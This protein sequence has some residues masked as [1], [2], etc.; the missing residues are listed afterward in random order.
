MAYFKQLTFGGIAPAMSPRLLPEP[1]GQTSQNIDFDSGR[2]TP[3]KTDTDALTLNSANKKSI[4]LYQKPLYIDAWDS[5]KT[6]VAGNLV[7]H[8]NN[9]WK[10][11]QGNNNQTPAGS[12]SANWT[13]LGTTADQWFQ[14]DEANISAHQGPI[15]NDT[16]GR[17]Y[18]TGE[19]YPRISNY[20]IAIQSTTGPYPAS[21]NGSYRLGVPAPAS[22]QTPTVSK[23]VAT[24][25]VGA[26]SYA[27]H[28]L[29]K[30]EQ[31]DITNVYRAK[32]SHTSAAANEPPNDTFWTDL[33][34]LDEQ[35]PNDVSYV[36]TI[37]S[38]FGEEGPPS[39]A[40]A[41]IQ[42]VDNEDVTV[43]LNYTAGSSVFNGYNISTSGGAKVYIYRSNTGSKNTT[44]QFAGEVA[45]GTTTFTD[46]NTALTLAE[47]LP[48]TT[49]IHPPNDDT[50]LYP[51][52]PLQ[53]LT[54]LPNGM[55]AGFTG[56]RFC[57]SEPFLPHAWPIQYR[58]TVDR[59]IVAIA[60]TRNGIMAL[61]DGK[62]AFVTGQNPSAMVSTSID[63][64][65][66]CINKSSVVDMGDYVLYAGP[67]G[68][69]RVEN[70]QG[71]VL[72]EQQITPQQWNSSTG[73]FRPSIIKAFR[74][75]NTYVAFWEDSG[76]YGG[77]AYDPRRGV[78]TL[79]NLSVS[80]KVE[81]GFF[82]ER[83]NQLY[84]IVGDKI[85][86]YRGST[87]N[88]TATYKSRKYV[89]PNPLSMSWVSV[90][91]EGYPVTVKVTA[92]STEI[93]NYSIS[94]SAGV[95]TQTTTTPSNTPSASLREPIMRLPAIVGQV[96]EVEVS[97][98]FEVN[99]FC[100]SQSIEEIKT[101]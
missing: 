25:W 90:H 49:W 36:Y 77:W 4:F 80:A 8:S 78:N 56:K 3:I 67:D 94:F 22:S 68:L 42:L 83:D 32:S 95:Y 23:I 53:Q 17:L 1:L 81:S 37:V 18:W 70:T 84:L 11:A 101:T 55:F 41:A 15:I 43:T 60:A 16:L 87:A 26:Q 52:G 96:W 30:R 33:G 38:N 50:A 51:T 34:E 58:I 98:A 24:T 93:A 6:Y 59:T 89:T 45:F 63:L 57:V 66:A 2:L 85:K 5:S 71:Q 31:N 28:K 40:S 27:Q 39:E 65:Q 10:A 13:D 92:D 97:S 48:S 100:L 46:Y 47:V 72:T 12:N 14:W 74:Y 62:P 69:C 9:I 20:P 61:T 7:K 35:I 29:V 86:K 82:D 76:S 44:F 99:D 91:A 54:P 21:S 88:T 73:I 79:S 64:A 19:D 75:E